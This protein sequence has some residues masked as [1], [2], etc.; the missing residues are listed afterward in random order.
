MRSHHRGVSGDSLSL[1]T[2][3]R[4][5]KNR[6]LRPQR[7]N[8]WFPRL[9]LEQLEDRT[10]LDA[11]SNLTALQAASGTVGNFGPSLIS[12]P[13]NVD[14][15]IVGSALGHQ[16]LGVDSIFS[17]IDTALAGFNVNTVKAAMDPKAEL[18]KELGSGFTVAEVSDTQVLVTY[19]QSAGTPSLSIDKNLTDFFANSGTNYLSDISNLSGTGTGTFAGSNQFSMT[20]GANSSGFFVN[21]GAVPLFSSS[22]FSASLALSGTVK[23]GAMI[24]TV[25]LSSAMASIDLKTISDGFQ[26]DPQSVPFCDINDH[27]RQQ[28]QWHDERPKPWL[29]QIDHH[30]D[31]PDVSW[32]AERR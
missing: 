13:L 8:R 32:P 22:D 3:D 24:F 1:V 26:R 2:K 12:G 10:L 28:L 16:I 31:L 21:K 19:T 11:A 29:Y 14:L 4:G 20:F 15:P 25:G 30:W 27:N 18:Q 6:K 7:P 17:S 5:L 23:V 9:Q